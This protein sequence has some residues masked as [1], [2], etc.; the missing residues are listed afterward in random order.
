M[1]NDMID[2]ELVKSKFHNKLNQNKKKNLFLLYQLLNDHKQY[3]VQVFDENPYTKKNN[4]KMKQ[5]LH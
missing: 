3:N 5:F 1:L 4:D 2:Q